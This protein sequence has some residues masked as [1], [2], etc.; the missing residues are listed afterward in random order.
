MV[1]TEQAL[2]MVLGLG[3]SRNRQRDRVQRQI[4]YFADCFRTHWWRSG[5]P[6][7]GRQCEALPRSLRKQG[8]FCYQKSLS[9]QPLSEIALAGENGLS[10]DQASF[11]T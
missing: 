10:Q 9:I 11:F 8:H 2:Q 4:V 3:S 6:L 5:E 7:C 1:D